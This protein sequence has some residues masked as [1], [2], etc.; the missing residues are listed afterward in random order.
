[1]ILVVGATGYLGGM[2]TRRLLQQGHSVR[3]AVRPNSEYSELIN[4]GAQATMADLRDPDSLGRAC[5]GIDVVITTA[6]SA[7]RGDPDTVTTV[8]LNGSSN[9]IRAAREAGVRQFTFI[10]AHGAK[11]C[12]PVLFLQAKART[13]EALEASGLF[14]TIFAPHV[15]M[16]IWI[17]IV[18]GSALSQNRP[19]FLVGSGER[20]HSFI[21]AADVA[22]F[23]VAAVKN[24]LPAMRW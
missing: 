20:K 16:D 2:I 24:A 22:A 5:E 11:V 8:D 21:A 7:Q 19:V 10:S 17:P 13:E 9:L 1:M 23:A 4:L 18:V 15:F 3:V 14:Y 6:N 12:H